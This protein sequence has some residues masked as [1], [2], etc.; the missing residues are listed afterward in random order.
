MLPFFDTALAAE[1]A[2]PQRLEKFNEDV[3]FL[4]VHL[5]QYLSHGHYYSCVWMH[6]TGF[7][8][9]RFTTIYDDSGNACK[10]AWQRDSVSDMRSLT[11]PVK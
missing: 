9:A 11:R 6:S 8:L 7:S 4:R 10:N 3:P 2:S 5:G 1:P